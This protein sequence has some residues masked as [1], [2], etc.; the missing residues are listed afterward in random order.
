MSVLWVY[1]YSNISSM[2]LELIKEGDI[3]VYTSF[4]ISNNALFVLDNNNPELH[5]NIT[6]KTCSTVYVISWKGTI[7]LNLEDK[8][9]F[10]GK[11]VKKTQITSLKRGKHTVFRISE[12]E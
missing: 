9:W 12:T 4:K 8:C 6:A 1:P 3:N 11:T 7:S 5:I 2:P 10:F